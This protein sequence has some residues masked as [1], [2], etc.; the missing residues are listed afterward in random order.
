MKCNNFPSFIFSDIMILNAV[1]A[2]KEVVA[3][4]FKV[5]STHFFRYAS[6]PPK[7]SITDCDQS[8]F[9]KV[10][11]PLLDWP[12]SLVYCWRQQPL[13][14]N[15]TCIRN[16][17]K[18]HDVCAMHRKKRVTQQNLLDA[19]HTCKLFTGQVP[20][21]TVARRH[22]L[23]PTSNVNPVPYTEPAKYYF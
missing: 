13:L 21:E 8:A 23:G 4:H 18:D 1:V 15:K 10:G 20:N 11:Q 6:I 16:P 12:P 7:T 9:S 2:R 19:I 3:A 14:S 5:Q 17:S 22:A